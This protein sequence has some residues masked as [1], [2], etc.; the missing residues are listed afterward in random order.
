[1]PNAPASARARLE[2]PYRSNSLHFEYAAPR[3][4]DSERSEFQSYLEG[5]DRHWSAWS[6][7]PGRSYT[8]LPARDYRFHVRARDAR[9]VIGRDAVFAFSVLRPWYRSWPAYVTYALL[10]LGAMIGVWKVQLGRAQRAIQ[11]DVEHRELEKLRELDRMKS[12]FFTDISHEFRTPLTLILAPVGQ[13]LQE[14]ESKT[15]ADARAKL[16]MVRRN[17]ACR[18]PAQADL[19]AARSL[20]GR[21]RDDAPPGRRMRPRRTLE[22]IVFAF[23]AAAEQQG[24]DLRWEDSSD[25]HRGLS[26][27]RGDREDRQQPARQRAEVHAARRRRSPS[28]SATPSRTSGR[29]PRNR[30]LRHR[31]RHRARQ[32]PHIFNR[33]YQSDAGRSRE[34]IGVGLALVK[35]LVDLQGGTIESKAPRAPARSS[36]SASRKAARI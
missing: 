1:M 6:K 11:R 19:A 26:R 7:E 28:A 12:R 2:F 33:F 3:F 18:I 24:I 16:L 10:L 36:S 25:P 31:R 15:R 30:R 4:E 17:G 32:L 35:E 14:L 34:G 5:F 21:I 27:S 9:G 8:N 13:M 20:E 29:R 22:P 23:A